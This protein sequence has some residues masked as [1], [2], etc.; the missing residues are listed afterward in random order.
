MENEVSA[1][2]KYYICHQVL[3]LPID[4]RHFFFCLGHA[5]LHTTLVLL[6][7]L[8]WAFVRVMLQREAPIGFLHLAR[9][10]ILCDAKYVCG[11]VPVHL[12]SQNL[13]KPGKTKN[14]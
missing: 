10:R 2:M 8:C 14:V 12:E 6:S 9:G 13:V 1:R 3:H 4:L 11:L 5:L 7:T